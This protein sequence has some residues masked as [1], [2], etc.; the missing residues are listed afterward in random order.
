MG[1]TPHRP[2]R[3]PQADH[4]CRQRV[5]VRLVGRDGRSQ[6][7]VVLCVTWQE[8][9]ATEKAASDHDAGGDP[10]E[11]LG[12][13]GKWLPPAVQPFRFRVTV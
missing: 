4:G 12:G 1:T 10:E 13:R 2:V 3:V 6:V 9:A 8:D 7:V 5:V 11:A